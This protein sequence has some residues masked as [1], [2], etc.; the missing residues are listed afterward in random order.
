LTPRDHLGD[1]LAIFDVLRE[2]LA[3]TVPRIGVCAASYGA[4]LAVLLTGQRDISRLLLRAPALYEDESFDIRLGI[5]RSSNVPLSRSKVLERLQDYAGD[6]LILESG[7]DEVI[8]RGV[9]DA[10]L[11]AIG[12]PRHE[13]IEGA[14]HALTEP[15]WNESFMSIIVDWFRN[16]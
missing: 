2:Q 4:H 10:Y 12:N 14:S 1:V 9:V 3:V 7:C 8:S 5:D 16:V 6:T 11:K 15:Q 13:I